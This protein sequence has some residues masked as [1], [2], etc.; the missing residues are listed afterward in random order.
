VVLTRLLQHGLVLPNCFGDR[1][2]NVVEPRGLGIPAIN[3]VLEPR[4]R[5]P[6]PYRLRD[7]AHTADKCLQHR[8][9]FFVAGVR[10]AGNRAHQ[11]KVSAQRVRCSHAKYDSAGA[12]QVP[13]ILWA[14]RTACSHASRMASS[15]PG[16]LWHPILIRTV[17]SSTTVHRT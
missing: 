6:T 17:P 7:A 1:V 11:V 15:P 12:V 13:S 9:D 2:Q 8:P 4:S 5:E 10:G 16:R 3:H 14:D